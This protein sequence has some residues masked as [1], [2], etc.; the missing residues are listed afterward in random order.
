MGPVGEGPGTLDSVRHQLQG[1]WTLSSL[2]VYPANGK[3]T[4]LKASGT[5]T[6]DEFGNLAVKAALAESA[7][8]EG[9]AL[10]PTA[11]TYSGRAVIDVANRKM[12]LTDIEGDVPAN[13]VSPALASDRARY[14]EFAGDELRISLK[15]PQ[16]RTTALLVWKKSS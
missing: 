6:Y 2:E 8:V 5:L 7:T 4:P 11:L 12:M 14:Y 15:D 16:G 9:V 3:A 1:T 13:K 10:K